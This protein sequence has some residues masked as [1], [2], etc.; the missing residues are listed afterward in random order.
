MYKVSAMNKGDSPVCDKHAVEYQV[1][2]EHGVVECWECM[3]EEVYADWQ[4]EFVTE[5]V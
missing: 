1:E 5:R 3:M 4:H 2:G